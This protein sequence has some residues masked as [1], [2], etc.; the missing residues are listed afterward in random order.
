MLGKGWRKGNS[1]KLEKILLHWKKTMKKSGLI[2]NQAL[3]KKNCTKMIYMAAYKLV[4][5]CLRCY[6]TVG[7]DT[8]PV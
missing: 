2:V 3:G 8:G 6:F 1:A 5:A 7:L 4:N